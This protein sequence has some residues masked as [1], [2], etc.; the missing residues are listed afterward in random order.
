MSPGWPLEAFANG[1]VSYIAD[2]AHQLPGMEA[3]GNDLDQPNRGG[4]ARR[5][6]VRRTARYLKRNMARRVV[7]SLGIVLPRNGRSIVDNAGE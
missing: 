6:S 7:D 2:M 5:G 1:I 3:Q 4:R